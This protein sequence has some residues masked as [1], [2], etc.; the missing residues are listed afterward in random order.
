M[1]IF[2]IMKT[3]I[4]EK[5]NNQLFTIPNIVSLF[6]IILVGIAAYCLAKG[7]NINAFIIYVTA[8]LTDFLDGFLA[9]LLQQISELGKILDPL[10]DKLMVI[11]AVVILCIQGRMPI[12][13]VSIVLARDLIIMIAGLILRSKLNFVIPSIMIG[14]ITA[15]VLML[16]FG[17]N[18]LYFYY[19]EYLYY[20]SALLSLISLIAYAVNANKI[21]KNKKNKANE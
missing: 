7:D 3:I 21:L 16:T 10:A 9:R 2:V 18:I 13:F 6:R 8:M 14:K 15:T 19:I 5:T 4:P 20:L 11:S 12:W 1:L 17:L